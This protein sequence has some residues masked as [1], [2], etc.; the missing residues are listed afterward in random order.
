MVA[1]VAAAALGAFATT[2]MTDA[3][4]RRQVWAEALP[5]LA[6][7]VEASLPRTR[8]AIAFAI[9]LLAAA[10]RPGAG[11]MAAAAFGWLLL[12]MAW[13]DLKRGVLPD[14]ATGATA[15][16]GLALAAAGGIDRTVDALLGGALGFATLAATAALYR[17]I[18]GVDGLGGGDARLL[19]AIG[20][21]LGADGVAAAL[22]GA[23][24]LGLAGV[25]T[26]HVT[27]RPLARGDAVP[28]GPFLCAAGWAVFLLRAVHGDPPT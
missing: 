22:L 2:R 24:L 1:I 8:F 18:R 7:R 10:L 4:L 26:L 15:V 27:G 11:A 3:L 19:G 14:V 23:A 21:W 16:L 12:M 13:I 28:F 20:F 5:P 17:R 9:G 6:V 25:A